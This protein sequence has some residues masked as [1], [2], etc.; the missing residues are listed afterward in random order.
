MGAYCASK[1]GVAMLV[2]VAAL[3]SA[4]PASAPTR[5]AGASRTGSP[6]AFALPGIVEEYEENT[7]LGRHASPDEIA[8]LVAFLASDEAGFISGSLH[9]A[10]GAAH[11]KRYPDILGHL[12]SLGAS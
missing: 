5:S 10:D 11:T 6:R 1:A 3:S 8:N 7:P 4:R 2:Q 9:L 12:E